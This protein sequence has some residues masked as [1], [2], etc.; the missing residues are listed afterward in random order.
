MQK[1]VGRG[2]NGFC[3]NDPFLLSA[4]CLLPTGVEE[5]WLALNPFQK[6]IGI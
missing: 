4:V 3:Q 2:S 6:R 5:L 1:A